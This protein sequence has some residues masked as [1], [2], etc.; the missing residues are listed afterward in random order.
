MTRRHHLPALLLAGLAGSAAAAPP[1]APVPAAGPAS[2]L[3]PVVAGVLDAAPPAL[4]TALLD[5]ARPGALSAA[6]ESPLPPAAAPRAALQA[7]L[8]AAHGAA[9]AP[10][11]D[12][13]RLQR[14]APGAD[15]SLRDA[16]AASL[17]DYLLEPAQRCRKPLFDRYL[18]TRYGA[19]P[20]A[21]PCPAEAPFHVLSR[22]GDAV[23]QRLDPARVRAIHLV[24]AGKNRALASRFGH[25]ALRLVV[26][27][28]AAS[29]DEACDL[30][31]DEH[32]ML[33]Y[34]AHVDELA[35]S[36]PKALGGGYRVHLFANRFLDVYQE[37]AIDEFRSLHSLPLTLSTPRREAMVRELAE[38]HFRPAGAYRY[39]T[40]NCATL[41]QDALRVLWP[42][43]PGAPDAHGYWLRPDSFFA[44]ITRTPGVDTRA[45]SDP[46]QAERIGHLFPSTRP[47]YER[48]ATVVAAAMTAPGFATLEEFLLQAPPARHAAR[49][50]DAAYRA[51]L[52][53]DPR[54]REAQLL[55]EEYA[56]LRSERELHAALAALLARHDAAGLRR[57]AQRRVPAAALPLFEACLLRPL[58][59]RAAPLLSPDGLPLAA[60]RPDA[61]AAAATAGCR[62]AAAADALREA[63][64]AFVSE[65]A[66]EGR[67]LRQ[68][69]D[70]HAGSIGNVRA[71]AGAPAAAP[72]GP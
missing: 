36:L 1:A 70:Y 17:A 47:Y 31:L 2:A 56:M 62:D 51:R 59:Q 66:A 48:A 71:L 67:R 28:S 22:Q 38:L 49:K 5:A 11:R 25:V 60:P 32:L 68:L 58:E 13:R 34:R 55:L 57:R 61:A 3:P 29:S 44:A 21:P 15:A 65:N 42:E 72:T 33:G 9:L 46:A 20:A 64:A 37:Y 23:W 43:F 7:W 54:L 53:G 19:P 18:R 39:V 10:D 35:L 41:L 52:A 45:L 26:C 24:F 40:R 4:R 50:A 63:V 6:D 27:P 14:L 12:F 69:A 30:N 8:R 16:Y